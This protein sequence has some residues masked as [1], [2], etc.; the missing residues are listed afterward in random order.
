MAPVGEETVP[1][2]KVYQLNNVKW[3]IE[4][5]IHHFAVP[6]ETINSYQDHETNR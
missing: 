4:L 1:F 5:E 2:T 3:R 6:N